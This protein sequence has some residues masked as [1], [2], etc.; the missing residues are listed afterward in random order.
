LLRQLKCSSFLWLRSNCHF[1]WDKM[2]P[3]RQFTVIPGD[4]VLCTKRSV[5]EAGSIFKSI[6]VASRDQFNQSNSNLPKWF[7]LLTC[8]ILF[9]CINVDPSFEYKH[10]T[11]TIWP[12]CLPSLLT[13][14]LLIYHPQRTYQL[15][16]DK[17]I[18]LLL[19]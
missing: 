6:Y 14:Y 19:R 17:V 3:L 11:I 10:R 1:P 13:D 5:G 12:F 8:F 9:T 2:F 15:L 16:S 4:F 7:W 18:G